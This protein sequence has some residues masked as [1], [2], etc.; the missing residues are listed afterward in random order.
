MVVITKTL[1]S[2]N[3]I[4]I[5][6]IFDINCRISLRTCPSF[7]V[8]LSNFVKKS[9]WAAISL[10]PCQT[11][12]M[13]RLL[14]GFI[15]FGLPGSTLVQKCWSHSIQAGQWLASRLT[16]ICCE[17]IDQSSERPVRSESLKLWNKLKPVKILLFFYFD[18]QLTGLIQNNTAISNPRCIYNQWNYF[19]HRCMSKWWSAD[20]S[21]QTWCIPLE[22]SK[23]YVLCLS[24][25]SKSEIA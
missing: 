9:I 25:K 10:M 12:Q 17:I 6:Q 5:C 24:Y 21:I 16:V 1:H 14:P 3:I 15:L 19:Q 4:L 23:N 7:I 20:F 11:S 13:N 8:F 18:S 2:Y 22:A